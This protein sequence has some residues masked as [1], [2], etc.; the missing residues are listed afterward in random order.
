M[1]IQTCWELAQKWY[2]GRLEYNWQRPT[3]E[4]AQLLFNSLGLDDEFWNL[5]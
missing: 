2:K 5:A 1:S 4:K 3:Q